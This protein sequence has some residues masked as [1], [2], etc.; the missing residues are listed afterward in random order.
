M[1]TLQQANASQSR[2]ETVGSYLSTA[3]YDY[4]A[5]VQQSTIYNDK[6]QIGPKDG[7]IYTKLTNQIDLTLTYTF[8]SDLQVQPTIT[9]NVNTTLKTDAWQY[10][11]ASTQ[12]TSTTHMPIVLVLPSFVKAEVEQTKARID[13]ETGVTSG[14][15]SSSQPYFV[16]EIKPTF[17]IEAQTSTGD[18]H[19]TFQPTILVNSTHTGEGDVI[20]IEGLTQAGSGALTQVLNGV[21]QDVVNQRYA[22]YVL[23]ATAVVGLIY[24][25]TVMT[26]TQKSASSTPST[27]KLLEPY[28]HLIIEAQE[29]T[30]STTSTVNVTSIPELVKAAETLCK[31]IL[32]IKNDNEEV[33]CII[34]GTTKY[35][36]TI[37][38]AAADSSG[39]AQKP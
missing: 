15:Y 3:T 23:M 34:E 21:N 31:P 7:P 13:N 2:T 9:Y 1:V 22:S 24:S 39:E 18:I 29:N 14:F 5:K 26:K 4:T 27:Q 35:Q 17:L 30:A 37:S 11:L 28:K 32:H 19:Q 16:Y 12:K 20:K 25:I 10:Q 38:A 8:A 33:L 6:T 36:Y